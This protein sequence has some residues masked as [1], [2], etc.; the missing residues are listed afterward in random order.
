MESQLNVLQSFQGWTFVTDK[1]GKCG[2][3]SNDG[4]DE[5]RYV[6]TGIA[7]D[8]NYCLI[9]HFVVIAALY[10]FRLDYQPTDI[11]VLTSLCVRARAWLCVRGR[12]LCFTY[13]L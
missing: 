3:D 4:L 9:W 13:I 12:A 10:W 6:M 5:H 1:N 11:I 7:L 2:L 8:A